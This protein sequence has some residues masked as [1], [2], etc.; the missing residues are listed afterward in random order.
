[1]A[2]SASDVMHCDAGTGCGVQFVQLRGGVKRDRSPGPPPFARPVAVRHIRRM[3][4]FGI[5]IVFAALFYGAAQYE[6]MNGWKWAA[7]SVAVSI[8]VK[9]LPISGFLPFFL[10][11]VAL[12]GVL[13]WRNSKRLEERDADRVRHMEDDRKMRQDR[14]RRGRD[15]ALRER[16]PSQ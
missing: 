4:G 8:V 14:V 6:H 7:A 1:M 11:Q 9:V 5:P 13:W 15:E 12:F 2:P 3:F 10:A 16:G